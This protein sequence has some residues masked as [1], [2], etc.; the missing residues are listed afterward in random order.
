MPHC[1]KHLFAFFIIWGMGIARVPAQKLRQ[2]A[3]FTEE[4]ARHELISLAGQITSKA[5]W[6]SR[7]KL[8]RQGIL[9][10]AE[11]QRFK[12]GKAPNASIHSKKLLQGYSVENVFFES[13]PGIYVTG[14]LYKPLKVKGNTPAILAPHGHG[15]DPRFGEA[16]Q[17]RCATLARMGATVFAYDMLG[18]GDMQQCPH[19][20]EKALK[21]QII[22]GLRALDFLY[23]L[24]GIDKARIGISG[25][26]GGGTQTIL[27]A[28]L[29]DRIKV[30]VPVVMVSAHFFGGCVCESGM[31]IHERDTHAGSNVD[32]AACFAPKPQLL[33]SDG[34]DWTKNTPSV[35]Y[36]FLQKIYSLY[37]QAQQVENVHLANEK[38]DYGPSKRAAAYKFFQKHLK[39]DASQ[40]NESKNTLLGKA[41]LSVFDAAHPLPAHALQGEAAVMAKI[42]SL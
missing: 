24:K 25:E 16:T 28:A 37:G 8:L 34:D 12:W 39:L 18:Y 38:H 23:H 14:N 17:Q 20:I 40:M 5:D 2:G 26:S 21:L 42:N 4:K 19:K 41:Q 7:A 15:S 9:Q 22:N 1:S 27:L 6:E 31:P 35:E 10:G 36:P 11:L 30:S 3:Y 32:F 29:D 13:V 33:I